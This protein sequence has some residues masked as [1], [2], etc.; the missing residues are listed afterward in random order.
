[1]RG[2][3]KDE[4]VYSPDYREDA[5]QKNRKEQ[6]NRAGPGKTASV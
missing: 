1:M 6:E 5:G 3:R 2:G 4:L